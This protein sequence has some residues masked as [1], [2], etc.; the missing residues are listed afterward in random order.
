MKQ[1]LFTP[2]GEKLDKANVLKEYPRP[3]FV[4][5]SYVNLNGEWDYRIEKQNKTI[6]EGKILVPFPAESILSGVEHALSDDEKLCYKKEIIL[7]K[8]FVKDKVFINFGAVDL[9]S[10]VFINGKKVGDHVGGY[11]A[12]SFEI[13]EFLNGEKEVIEVFVTDPTDKGSYSRGKQT[14]K[15]GGIWYGSQ[16]G[17]WQT[18]WLE[19]VKNQYIENIRFTPDIDNSTIKIETDLSG[20]GKCEVKIFDGKKNIYT[21]EIKESSEI[22]LKD[23]KLWS[24]E[25]P[26]LYDVKFSYGEDEVKSYFGMRKFSVGTDKEGMP[27]LMLNNEPYFMN[28]LLDQG[29]WP[30]GL[31]TAPSDEA[32]IYDIR[33]MK[34]MGFNTLRK[35]IKVEPMRWYYHCDR[36]GIIVWQDMVNGG[37]MPY[38]FMVI[39]TLPYL[40]IH[41]SDKNYKAFKR[42]DVE[43]RENYYCELEEMIEQLYNCTSIGCWVPFN[44]GWG[45][46]DAKEAY[47]FIKKLDQTRIID[48]ASGWHDQKIGD[49]KSKHI[50][51]KP[52]MIRPDK[53]LRPVC[54]TEF[55]GYSLRIDG[56]V[57]D[58]EKLFGYK[59]FKTLPK[60]E[61]A[62]VKLFTKNVI[63]KIKNGLS[64]TIYTQVSD[65]E[66]EI[67][68][69]VTYDRRVVK[70]N[71]AKIKELNDK[72]RL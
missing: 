71:V 46:F 6:K 32:L 31:Y 59:I 22:K 11:N 14:S 18:V 24:P 69:V 68:G 66:E 41:I 29:Y 34:D 49:M 28:G 36:L 9:I 45:Q 50:Y 38:N 39:G 47:E 16:A 40:G 37:E 17:I 13:S 65:V 4:R 33:L 30:D 15:G 2:W 54:I 55:G 48:H 61:D 42:E 26:F 72:I 58:D 12:F 51:F 67:N 23:V 8:T 44:E 10:E 20:E 1:K 5:D 53:L 27:R 35:H 21:G 64:A 7:N 57:Y 52:V 19:S 3:Q 63:K 70:L 62:Y 43:G 25:N 56:H 60:L